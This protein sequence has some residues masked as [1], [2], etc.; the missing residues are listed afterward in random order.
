MT[1]MPLG[2]SVLADRHA[3]QWNLV[4]FIPQPGIINEKEK[5]GVCGSSAASLPLEKPEH[6]SS[7][8]S[9]DMHDH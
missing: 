4:T 2:G 5:K 6:L 8:A 9:A 1:E 3:L 7:H